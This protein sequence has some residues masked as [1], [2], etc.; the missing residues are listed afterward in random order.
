MKKSK[1]ISGFIFLI[2]FLFS[3]FGLKAQPSKTPIKINN[4]SLESVPRAGTPL[5]SAPA[6]WLDCSHE[7]QTSV[8]IQPGYFDVTKKAK[9]GDTYVGMVVRADDSWEGISQRLRSPIVANSC[10]TFSIHLA[11][12]EIYNSSTKFSRELIEN[13][14]NP[15]KLRIYGG[16]TYCAKN[17]LLAESPLIAHSEWK[18]YNFRFEP[19]SSHSYIYLEVFYRTPSLFPYNGNLLIDDMSDIIPISCEDEV[20]VERQ[21]N[22][23]IVNILNPVS[24][25]IQVEEPN[26]TFT[27]NFANIPSKKYVIFLVNGKRHSFTFS[28][29]SKNINA[30]I[31]F[32][33]RINK[34]QIIANTEDGRSQ[35]TRRV[36]YNAPSVPVKKE[37][38]PEVLTE[39]SDRS[40]LRNGKVLSLKNVYFLADS[41]RIEVDN[42]HI[43]N[44][45]NEFLEINQDV[46]IEI[47]GHTNNRCGE[48]FC[49]SLSE[50]RAKSVVEYLKAKG[51]Q[52]N[53]L[54]YKGYGSSKPIASNDSS[55]GR[56]K[57]QRVEIKIVKISG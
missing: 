20:V 31:N 42:Y 35:E 47:M 9:N 25:G 40:K 11:R 1:N 19:I 10:Y 18:E 29:T 50:K 4:P 53:R 16:N 36:Y 52:S 17:E 3:N 57:N 51:I 55:K 26:F 37:F 21:I 41:S 49:I 44:E 39:L 43:L 7:G 46:T 38:K 45:L 2:F 54:T 8:D 48:S 12:S 30:E 24:D 15:T 22:P 14:A 33:E 56:Q 13:F 28:P 34:I 27:A 23:P 6:G 32:K 5:G